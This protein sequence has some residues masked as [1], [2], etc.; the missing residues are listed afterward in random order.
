V[1]GTDRHWPDCPHEKTLK[2][3]EASSAEIYDPNIGIPLLVTISPIFDQKGE[4]SQ[5]V[6]AAKDITEL[7]KAAR[8]ISIRDKAMASS[9]DGMAIAD[10]QGN[11]TYVNPAF[12]RMWGYDSAF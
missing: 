2:T 1:H 6:H 4:V 5:C 8:E 11:V 9:I 7:K 12:V 3:K 10:L